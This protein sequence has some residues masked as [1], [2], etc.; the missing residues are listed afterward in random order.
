MLLGLILQKQIEHING[1]K[2]NIVIPSIRM[3]QFREQNG[4][5]FGRIP[6]INTFLSC[7]S[8]K[9]WTDIKHR[10]FIIEYHRPLT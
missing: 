4:I 5:F 6:R 7:R 8:T 1:I 10:L 9:A 3:K 2:E